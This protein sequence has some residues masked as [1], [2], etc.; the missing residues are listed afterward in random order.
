RSKQGWHLLALSART[1][2]S[3]RALISRYANYL[4][5]TT[6]VDVQNLC[7]TANA[8]RGHYEHRIAILFR[9]QAELREKCQYADAT[10]LE[11]R[12][13]AAEQ[14]ILYK[15]S[16]VILDQNDPSE[17]GLLEEEKVKRTAIAE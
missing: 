14:G 4:N 10:G 11:N 12:Q 2:G 17:H 6:A 3:L 8:T 13:Q 16:R 7:Y 9:D 1:K 15:V 5:E